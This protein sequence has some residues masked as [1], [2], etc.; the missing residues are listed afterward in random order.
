MILFIAH[1]FDDALHYCICPQNIVVS[2]GENGGRWFDRFSVHAL[3][4]QCAN[5]NDNCSQS[6]KMSSHSTDCF[7]PKGMS[8]IITLVSKLKDFSVRVQ[9]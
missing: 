4:T 7:I 2:R 5:E 1:Q 3:F 6:Q 9:N 8:G